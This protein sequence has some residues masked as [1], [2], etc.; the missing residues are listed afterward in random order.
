MRDTSQGRRILW[1]ALALLGGLGLAIGGR[2]LWENPKR[3]D[4]SFT[5]ELRRLIHDPGSSVPGRLNVIGTG[6]GLHAIFGMTNVGT[7]VIED[8]R[9]DAVET[10]KDGAWSALGPGQ[11]LG[12]GWL[13]GFGTEIAVPWP[14]P[15]PL[16]STWRLRLRVASVRSPFRWAVNHWLGR[17]VFS[18]RESP[19]VFSPPVSPA[20]LVSAELHPVTSTESG[21]SVPTLTLQTE[22][23]RMGR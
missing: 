21:K 2:V 6:A 9:I 18:A 20:G 5:V 13:P 22:P 19:G 7:G 23:L 1:V 17:R 11:S 14:H 16:H 12:S 15:T 4:R 8:L 3:A 10:W